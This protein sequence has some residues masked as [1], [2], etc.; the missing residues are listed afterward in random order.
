MFLLAN[1][2]ESLLSSIKVQYENE[3]AKT[4]SNIPIQANCKTNVNGKYGVIYLTFSAE[5]TQK[6]TMDFE[7]ST[8]AF[9]LGAGEYFEYAVG[10]GNWTQ[11]TSTVSNISFGG[12]LGNLRL[13]GKSS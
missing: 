6:F 8:S 13:R 2:D 4:I 3:A 11:F 9:T 1:S 12:T 5:S 10:D 7:A